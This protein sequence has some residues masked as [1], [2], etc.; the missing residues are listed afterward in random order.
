ML[1]KDFCLHRT[2]LQKTLQTLTHVSDR[3]FALSIPF[4]VLCTVFD[5]ILSNIDEFLSIN[6]FANVFVSEDFNAH[7][8]DW[9]PFSG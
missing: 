3:L 4:F 5:S 2:Y 8:K 1:K 6:P 9:L 7:H